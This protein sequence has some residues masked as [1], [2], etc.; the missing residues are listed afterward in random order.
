VISDRQLLTAAAARRRAHDHAREL[1]DEF[2]RLVAQ[3][4]AEGHTVRSLADLLGIGPSTVQDITRRGNEL[5]D[6]Q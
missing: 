5:L 1:D 2:A 3:A 6:Q 4:R